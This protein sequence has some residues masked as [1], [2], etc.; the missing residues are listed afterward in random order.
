LPDT[1]KAG[2]P[3]FDRCQTVIVADNALAA[4][5]AAAR[6][7]ELGFSALVLSTFVEGEAREVAR[8]AVALGRE[9]AIRGRPA[10]APACL[11]LGGETT[12]TLRG[13]GRGGRNQ[14]L[15][16]AAALALAR[17]P[18]GKRIV[19]AS[20]AT[21]GSDG[22]TDSAGGLVDAATVARGRAAGLDAAAHLTRNDAYPFLE[23]SGDLL[24]T[25]PTQTNVNDL[26][27]IFVF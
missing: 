15:A 21:D 24:R 27:A 12:V 3:A 7:R 4:E 23:A 18:E 22:P 10:A 16:L 17:V 5:A 2:D 8:V 13:D 26:I 19:V 11:L 14:E 20:L 6:A 25:G 9:V 1:P